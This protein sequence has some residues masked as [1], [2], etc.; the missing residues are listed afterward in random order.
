M[1]DSELPTILL[2]GG[3]SG[4]GRVAARQL[5][6]SGST[7]AVVGRNASRGEA[8]VSES[9]PLAGT[10]DFLQYD[11]AT[12]DAVRALAKHVRGSYPT[13]DVLIHNAGVSVPDRTETTDGIEKTLAVNHLAPYLLTYELLETLRMGARGRVVVTASGL[14]TR[15]TFDFDNLQFEAQYDSLDAYARSK[16]CN[17]AFTPELADRLREINEPITVNCLH[18]GFVP[19]TGLFR[20]AALRKRIMIRLAAVLPWVGTSVEAGG[21]VLTALAT[22]PTYRTETGLYVG[23]EGPTEPSETARDRKNRIKLWEESASLVGVD[24]SWPA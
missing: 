5:A 14:H 22:D 7:V 24:S 18:P 9:R 12:Q 3:T 4:I 17:V 13:L 21:S 2:T 10:I 1:T 16:L 6:S 8:L 15:A 11:L 20:D 19:E 23:S